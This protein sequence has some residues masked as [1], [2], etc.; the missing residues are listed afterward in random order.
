[1]NP[2]LT[3]LLTLTAALGFLLLERA[4]ASRVHVVVMRGLERSPTAA[5]AVL[6][7]RIPAVTRLSSADAAKQGQR[8]AALALIGD[9]ER[10]RREVEAHEGPPDAVAGTGAI[11]WLA[12]VAAGGDAA[13]AEARLDDLSA[14]LEHDPNG[15]GAPVRLRVAGALGLVRA[16]LGQPMSNQTLQAARGFVAEGG[17][18]AVL[19]ASCLDHLPGE[20]RAGAAR[21]WTKRLGRDG[22]RAAGRLFVGMGEPVTEEVCGFAEVRE[23]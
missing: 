8:A 7:G 20:L 10:I 14:R 4:W 19:A 3:L 9:A 6:D 11:S 12:Y 22:K 23:E 21:G 17:A 1:M 13:L 15:I 5:L 18:I 16:T 2:L